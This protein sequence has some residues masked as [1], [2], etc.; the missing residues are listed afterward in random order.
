MAAILGDPVSLAVNSVSKL[1]PQVEDGKLGSSAS[2]ARSASMAS[3]QTLK[4]SR[5]DIVI[6]N[7][8]APSR[9]PASRT[10]TEPPS[11]LHRQAGEERRLEGRAQGEEL[12]QL[13]AGDPFNVPGRR[14]GARRRHPKICRHRRLTGRTRVAAGEGHENDEPLS[15]IGRPSCSAARLRRSPPSCFRRLDIRVRASDRLLGSPCSRSS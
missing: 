3:T 4:E 10:P 7:W 6:G 5:I 11:R 1:M 9:P 12:E 15:R 13:L 14:T 8:R 2:R